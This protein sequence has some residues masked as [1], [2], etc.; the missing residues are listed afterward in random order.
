M[1]S[2]KGFTLI[3]MLLVIAVIAILVAIIIPIVANSVRKANA[4]TDAANLRANLAELNIEMAS[5]QKTINEIVASMDTPACKLDPDAVM[6]VVYE[7]PSFV[8]VYFV[9][10]STYYSLEYLSDVAT[11]GESSLSTAKPSFPNGTWYTIGG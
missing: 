4:S 3:E 7:E 2:K 1:R 9:S 5:G 11:N 8:N 10:G 6:C